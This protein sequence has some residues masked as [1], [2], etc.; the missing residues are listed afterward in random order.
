MKDEI[1]L[2]NL[3]SNK[4]LNIKVNLLELIITNLSIDYG[5][6]AKVKN[7]LKHELPSSIKDGGFSRDGYDSKLDNLRMLRGN[8][9][10][11][12]SKLQK[13]YSDLTNI[14]ECIFL[15]YILV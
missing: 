8:E 11:Q 10:E 6:F 7:S 3:I 13:K 2:N 1:I 5:L 15:H 14:L 9:I 12:I 4:S